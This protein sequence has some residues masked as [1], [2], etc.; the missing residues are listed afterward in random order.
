MTGVPL[1]PCHDEFRGPRFDYVRQATGPML[2][3][4]H[5]HYLVSQKAAVGRS[6]LYECLTPRF[7]KEIQLTYPFGEYPH[8]QKIRRPEELYVPC[9][10]I[11]L[12]KIRANYT[13]EKANIRFQGIIAIPHSSHSASCKDIEA[14]AAIQCDDHQTSAIVMVDFSDIGRQI[15]GPWSCTYEK[16]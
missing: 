5:H 8:F 15:T 12:N 14:R 6:G 3:T 10:A 16:I 4:V 13:P 9:V 7:Y 2:T 1:A 11:H